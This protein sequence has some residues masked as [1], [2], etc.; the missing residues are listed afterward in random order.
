MDLNERIDEALRLD[1]LNLPPKP[2]VVR[3]EW[4]PYEDWD[5]EESLK[6]WVILD[7]ATTDEEILKGPIREIKD[8]IIGSLRQQQVQ[9]FPYIFF[10]GESEYQELAKR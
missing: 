4:E 9:L 1:R 2:R 3:L 10:A 7:D 5:G 8:E 6:V